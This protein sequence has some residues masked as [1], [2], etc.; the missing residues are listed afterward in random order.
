MDVGMGIA[1]SKS[2]PARDGDSDGGSAKGEDRPPNT[3]G[4]LLYQARKLTQN[5]LTAHAP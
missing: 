5:S 2:A 4:R 1:Y 3:L